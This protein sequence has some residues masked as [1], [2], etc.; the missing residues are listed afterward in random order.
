MHKHFLTFLLFTLLSCKEERVPENILSV[1]KMAAIL[2]DVHL[3]EGKIQ[4]LHLNGDTAKLTFGY[5]ERKIFEKHQVD[6][7]HYKKSFGYHLNDITTMDQIYSR[8]V[9]SLNVRRQVTRID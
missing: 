7:E 1:D 4:R 5:Y 8:V 9:D 3:A 2:V 6:K